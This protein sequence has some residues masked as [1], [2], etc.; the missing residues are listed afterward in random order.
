MQGIESYMKS[1]QEGALH[2]DGL[3]GRLERVCVELGEV[4]DTLP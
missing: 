4:M 2:I 1:T 3:Q